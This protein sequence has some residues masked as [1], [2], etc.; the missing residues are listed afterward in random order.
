MNS[1]DNKVKSLKP[2]IF[3]ALLAA[4]ILSVVAIVSNYYGAD[5]KSPDYSYDANGNMIAEYEQPKV[6]INTAT[7]EELD[8][9]K[10]IGKTIAQNI[11][12]YRNEHGLFYSINQL[13]NGYLVGRN[14]A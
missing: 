5:Y 12:D 6:D 9:I 1:D 3:G 7:A 10:G 2:L 13:T 8:K 14:Y 4:L 11:V